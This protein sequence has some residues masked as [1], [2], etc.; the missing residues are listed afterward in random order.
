MLLSILTFTPNN[1]T[2]RFYCLRRNILN[3]E[4]NKLV[5]AWELNLYRP[6]FI[7]LEG[8]VHRTGGEKILPSYEP[9]ELQ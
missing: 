3:M 2:V 5:L 7:V 1:L 9:C 4:K 6:G 8:P